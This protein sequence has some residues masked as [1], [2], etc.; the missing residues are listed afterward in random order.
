M[1]D[2]E[3]EILLLPTKEQ[4]SHEDDDQ[5]VPI[6]SKKDKFVAW[7]KKFFR[8]EYSLLPEGW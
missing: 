4:S 6:E 5:N 1:S 8:K 2:K 7:V 3:E